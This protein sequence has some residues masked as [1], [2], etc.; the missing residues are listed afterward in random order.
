M[1]LAANR[2]STGVGV[3]P[4]DGRIEV[5]AD[6]TPDPDL[7]TAS[8]AL[9]T[10]VTLAV[11]EWPEHDLDQIEDRGIP[12]IA[13][14]AHRRHTS[15]KG[16]LARF[17]C[18]PANPFA[19]DPTM[20]L[21]ETNDGRQLSLRQIATSV[22]AKFR[23][24]IRAVSNLAVCRHV[25]A[26]LGGRA[27]SLLDFAERPAAYEDVGRT[28]TVE[29]P[30]GSVAPSLPLRTNHSTSDQRS[31]GRHRL[32]H[33]PDRENLGWFEIAF[34]NT[35]TGQRRVFTLDELADRCAL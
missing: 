13:D 20:R 21:W 22:A 18:F 23:R 27:R 7:M 8:A 14:F 28:I 12:V 15:R 26:V 10:G 34:R 33:L 1:L 25:F 29:T 24:S 3:R 9:I 11:A 16:F 4:R 19:N 6:F 17:D 31:T 2:C 35:R 5:T 32:F 30:D